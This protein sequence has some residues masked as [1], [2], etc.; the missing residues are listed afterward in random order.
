MVPMPLLINGTLTTQTIHISASDA[1]SGI[2]SV[3]YSIDGG[4]TVELYE[5]NETD[6]SLSA[7]KDGL[8]VP[9]IE[10][11]HTYKVTVIDHALNTM[12]QTVTIK[13]DTV[14]PELSG[15]TV[16]SEANMTDMAN[17]VINFSASE[18]GNFYYYIVR[19]GEPVPDVTTVLSGISQIMTAGNQNTINLT[20]LDPNTE[21]SL[22]LAA[23]DVAGNKIAQVTSFDFTTAKI[24]FDI[25][26][27]TLARSSFVYNGTSQIPD[28]TVSIS[29]NT[30]PDSM[31]VISYSNSNGGEGNT[32]NAG[33]ITVTVTALES[34]EFIGTADSKPEYEIKKAVIKSDGI[35]F[36][37]YS[38][39]YDGAAHNAVTSVIGIPDGGAVSYS[40]STDNGVTWSE[41]SSNYPQITNAGSMLVKM[42]IAKDNY[43]DWVS[44]PMTVAVVKK[45]VTV[46]A[47]D[48]TR[49][50]GEKNPAFTLKPLSEGLLAGTDTIDNLK[51]TLSTEATE[52]SDAGTYDITGTSLSNNYDVTVEKG[53]LTVEKAESIITIAEGKDTITK[54]FGDAAFSSEC[55]K[56]GDGTLTYTVSGSKNAEEVTVADDQ[57]ITVDSAGKITIHRAGSAV[58][59]VGMA[60][61]KNY[62]AA[63]TKDIVVTIN[64]SAKEPGLTINDGKN[65]FTDQWY[66]TAQTMHISA[67]DT[68]SG[69]KSV[70]YSVDNGKAVTLSVISEKDGSFTVPVIEGEHTYEVTVMDNGLNMTTQKVTIRQDTVLPELTG[71]T[72]QSEAT[73]TDTTATVNFTASES[74]NVYYYIV[75]KGEPVP[76]VTTVLG[77]KSQ[78][79]TAGNQN[80]I[81]LTELDPGK[82][83]TL[84]LTA[85]DVAGNMTA[86]LTPFDFTTAK[87]PLAKAQVTL[88]DNSLSYNGT[89]QIPGVTVPD[90]NITK[91]YGI[92]KPK[93]MEK[94]K[95]KRIGNKK[96]KVM[97]KKDNLATGYQIRYST[98]KKFTSKTTKSVIIKRSGLLSKKIKRLKHRK[99]YYVQVRAYKKSGELNIYG[100]WSSASHVKVK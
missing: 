26:Q 22:Y 61:T 64:K 9:V 37:C 50:Y 31:Y 38:G 32:T 14:L 87:I 6:G 10:G 79:M 13:Q 81:S 48:C 34:G 47:S 52:T 20:K 94:P 99:K 57:V 92:V 88:A 77:G 44:A 58:I 42:K 1:G 70:T 25:A 39:A 59:H 18:S 53:A 98:S 86:Q 23:T 78:S 85:K 12:T 72:A 93:T 60:E 82:D 51:V 71:I 96:I 17:A 15:I 16:Q 67:L 35:G 62:K 69:I 8:T 29:G 28:V 66:T 49:K 74:G 89:S 83:Y 68:G 80:T 56:T 73:M 3:T 95:V 7:A 84:Y 43:E 21:F 24:P 2:K 76:D 91:T 55:T 11:E 45:S 30:I 19:K 54:T 41:Y 5:A 27:V 40:T 33:N 97:W 4:D 63:V 36:T 75:K 46:T 100:N 65:A 90:T